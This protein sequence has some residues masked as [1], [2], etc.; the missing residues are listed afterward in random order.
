MTLLKPVGPK[1]AMEALV[2]AAQVC[3]VIVDDTARDYSCKKLEDA[4]ATIL[5]GAAGALRLSAAYCAEL[6]YGPWSMAEGWEEALAADE[7]RGW[8]EPLAAATAV[9]KGSGSG[10]DRKPTEEDTSPAAQSLYAI[11]GKFLHEVDYAIEMHE[12]T[13]RVVLA[14]L[15]DRAQSEDPLHP[16]ECDDVYTT[17]KNS[18]ETLRDEC[19]G[20]YKKRREALGIPEFKPEPA[21]K[22][23]ASE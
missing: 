12:A 14:L 21:A 16:E 5:F 7:K 20:W 9:E 10:A 6:L 13:T 18:A 2:N 1:E 3:A 19:G 8:H 11:S 4:P 17:L 23:E 22:Q 15:L